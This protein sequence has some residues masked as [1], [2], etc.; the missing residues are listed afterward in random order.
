M[1]IKALK[2]IS[3][4]KKELIKNMT[5]IK[6]FIRDSYDDEMYLLHICEQWQQ[7]DEENSDEQIEQFINWK[8][9][10]RDAKHDKVKFWVI[11]HDLHTHL[12]NKPAKSVIYYV[13]NR[14]IKSEDFYKDLFRKLNM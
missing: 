3:P 7:E 2:G 5:S 13:T 9:T 6:D 8:K 10:E 14:K 12:Q 11:D 1:K 4:E